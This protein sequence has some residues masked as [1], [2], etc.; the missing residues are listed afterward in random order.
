MRTP[1]FNLLQ[2]S[3]KIT[4]AIVA[5]CGL[6]ACVTQNFVEDKPVVDRDFSD[7]QIA[8]TRIS[9]ALGYLKVGNTAQAKYNLEKAK[10]Y[11]PN[12]VAV[13]TAFA[14]YYESVGEYQ[15]TEES[16]LIALDLAEDDANTLNNFGVF[17]CRQNRVD[18]AEKYFLKAIAVPSYIRVSESYENIALCHLK[19]DQFDK[20]E[21]ALQRS[22]AHRPNGVTS[23][24]QMA[25]LQYA[26]ADFEQSATYLSRFEL[27]TRRFTPQAIALAFK[28]QKSLGNEHIANDYATM[29]LKM[30]PDSTQA[31]AYLDN[32]L[33]QIEADKL[34]IKYLRFKLIK[35]G[36]KIDRKPIVVLNKSKNNG[37]KADGFN[38]QQPQIDFT[39]KKL[40]ND[41]TIARKTSQSIAKNSKIDGQMQWQTGNAQAATNATKQLNQ[42][43]VKNIKTINTPA[44]AAMTITQPKARVDNQQVTEKKPQTGHVNDSDE[45]VHVVREGDNLYQ[46]SLKYNIL[47]NS[48]RRW[49]NLKQE[50]IH[51]GQVLRLTKPE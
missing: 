51:I 39:N 36:A 13:Y 24:L 27:A 19:V 49:N 14:H 1:I 34:A 6:N 25:Q 32:E 50:S 20:A 30:F 5:L 37:F 40:V 47:I 41:A 15:Q 11:S 28:V 17:L 8:T 29:L 21:H 45:L 18:E 26:K 9:L 31:K 43:A 23:L 3:G 7:D 10:Q 16:Y 44:N 33:K 22:I 2:N 4:L 35:S 42:A 46:I 48:I 12:L 38:Q